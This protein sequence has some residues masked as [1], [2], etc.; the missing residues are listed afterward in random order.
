MVGFKF[1]EHC[2]KEFE[3]KQKDRRFCSRSCID[4]RKYRKKNPRVLSEQQCLACS[5]AFAPR[6]K[7]SKFCSVACRNLYNHR[8]WYQNKKEQIH[9]QN[10]Q[11]RVENYEKVA[12]WN[13]IRQRFGTSRVSQ[14]LK[15]VCM[16]EYQLKTLLKEIQNVKPQ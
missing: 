7:I 10:E 15:D 8:L 3:Y 2:G 12:N 13:R 11:W 5:K 9:K 16:L 1:C 4:K 6:S 14:E